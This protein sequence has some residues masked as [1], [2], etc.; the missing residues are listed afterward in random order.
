MEGG[1]GGGGGEGL[2]L[3]AGETV[4]EVEV[5]LLATVPG[6]VLG[7]FVSFFGHPVPEGLVGDICRM[8]SARSISSPD[9]KN[10]TMSSLK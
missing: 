7:K 2:V 5:F 6:E 8:A 9:R 10:R 4:D 1:G 3:L